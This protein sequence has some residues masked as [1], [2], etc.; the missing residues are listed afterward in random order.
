MNTKE[1]AVI[2]FLRWVWFEC[3]EWLLWKNSF[4][5]NNTLPDE[6][7]KGNLTRA[8]ENQPQRAVISR[9]VIEQV[10]GRNL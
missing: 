1:F 6:G 7:I 3:V 2:F 4:E 5:E 8:G 10:I 9:W